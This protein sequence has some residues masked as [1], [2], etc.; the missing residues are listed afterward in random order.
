M[1][2]LN[3][4]SYCHFLRS[5]KARK[6]AKIVKI[7][8]QR[9]LQNLNKHNIIALSR[10]IWL[11][12]LELCVKSLFEDKIHNWLDRLT[13]SVVEVVK[14]A[15]CTVQTMISMVQIHFTLAVI[16]SGS[17]ILSRGYIIDDRSSFENG[18]LKTISEWKTVDF[19]FPS[20]N[21]RREAIRQQNFIEGN[22]VPI[23]VDIHYKGN[24][25]HVSA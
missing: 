7:R 4:W 22:A 12:W 16:L 14:K 25:S 18:K 10:V 6:I 13:S 3:W 20:E 5:N 19:V 17:G 8:E 11:N 9:S 23:D 15:V 24:S 21:H 1:C 2:V